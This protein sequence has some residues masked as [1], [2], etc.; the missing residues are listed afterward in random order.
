[1]VTDDDPPGEWLS[2]QEVKAAIE[3]LKRADEVRLL[4]AAEFLSDINGFDDPRGLLQEALV[5]ALAGQRQCPRKM[6][7]VPFLIGAMRSIANSAA[8]SDKRSP[9]DRFAEVG[10]GDNIDETEVPQM[11]DT[12]QRVTPE[13]QA[14]AQE[15]LRRVD[16]L[17]K[18]DEEIRLVLLAMAD[19]LQGNE[20][21]EE[22]GLTE[23]QHNTIRKRMLRQSK[24]L[25]E[26]WGR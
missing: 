23:T 22:L 14:A 16:E 1:M 13:R 2:L 18:D 19:G 15:M 11:G 24:P 17:F 6:A 26:I 5:R 7:F 10:E 3:A 25:A 8:K 12:V 9:I 4:K 20:L 21:R